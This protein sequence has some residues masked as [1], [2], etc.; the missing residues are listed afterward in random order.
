MEAQKHCLPPLKW[1]SLAVIL[2]IFTSLT[3]MTV[4]KAIIRALEFYPVL[5]I[6]L[7]IGLTVGVISLAPLTFVNNAIK[8][9]GSN[10]EETS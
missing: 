2:Y 1:A 10:K 7:F 8:R 6:S 3:V 9:K 5:I 4:V